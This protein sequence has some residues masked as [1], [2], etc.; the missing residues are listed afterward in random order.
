MRYL[1]GLKDKD[2]PIFTAGEI[3]FGYENFLIDKRQRNNQ[4]TETVE[5]LSTESFRKINI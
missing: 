1:F 2:S 3:V 4:Q 5:I